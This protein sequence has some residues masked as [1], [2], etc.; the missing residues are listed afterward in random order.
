MA[1]CSAERQLKSLGLSWQGIQADSN[2]SAG[3][4]TFRFQRFATMSCITT[5]SLLSFYCLAFI[6]QFHGRRVGFS[7]QYKLIFIPRLSHEADQ[8]NRSVY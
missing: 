8:L 2:T 7:Q 3:K 5:S 6:L 4:P 1:F